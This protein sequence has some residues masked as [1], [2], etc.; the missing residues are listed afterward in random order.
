V[1][2]NRQLRFQFFQRERLSQEA[3][4]P[5]RL[6]FQHRLLVGRARDHEKR[7]GRLHEPGLTQ[8]L[9]PVQVRHAQIAQYDINRADV[10]G[11]IQHFERLLAIR[12]GVDLPDSQASEH[13]RDQFQERR[14]V[15]HDQN[16]EPGKGGFFFAHP[17]IAQIF[18]IAFSSISTFFQ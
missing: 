11:F 16:P 6:R 4:N 1:H 7:I 14:V 2:H 9:Q 12:S 18:C 5:R 13:G 17:K 8:Q 10:A 15:V 3:G